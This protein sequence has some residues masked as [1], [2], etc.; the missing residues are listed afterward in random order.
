MAY[1]P[2]PDD[3]P[4]RRQRFL[5]VGELL[6]LFT[7]V[8][9]ALGVALCPTDASLNNGF[10]LTV[11]V[12]SELI[13]PLEASGADIRDTEYADVEGSRPARMSVLLFSGA[14]LL[15]GLGA[16]FAGRW[17]L[18]IGTLVLLTAPLSFFALP[19]THTGGV[20]LILAFIGVYRAIVKVELRMIALVLIVTVC[21]VALRS[22][23]PDLSPTAHSGENR[24]AL[25]VDSGHSGSKAL[26]R[27]LN[28][29][30]MIDHPAA[31]Y[32]RAQI[33]YIKG[34]VRH[35]A[36]ELSRMSRD[37]FSYSPFTETR[38]KI[39]DAYVAAHEGGETMPTHKPLFAYSVLGLSAFGLLASFSFYHL[40]TLLGRRLKRIERIRR[41][42]E[43]PEARK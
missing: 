28:T 11:D 23:G 35:V 29:S 5:L 4:T 8:V 3:L 6:R 24:A 25:F 2:F 10:R 32:V 12:P 26:S 41:K 16:A 18:L 13:E 27:Y 15:I 33:A 31:I 40:E 34:D 1:N 37:R 21:G 7:V 36:D 22:V 43:T 9:F 14:L 38:L 20:A 17:T 42:L 19:V 30:P 39:L